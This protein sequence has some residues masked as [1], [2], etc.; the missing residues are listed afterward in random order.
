MEKKLKAIGYVRVST[1][2]QAASGLSIEA[3]EAKIRQYCQLNDL[4]LVRIYC[5]AG[6]SGKSLNRPMV[7]EALRALHTKEAQT[8]VVLKL[9]RLS[10][11]TRDILDLADLCQKEE[12][13]LASLSEKLDT[14]SASGRLVLSVLA[15]MVQFEREQGVERTRL[16]LQAKRSRGELVGEVPVGFRLADDK[17]TLLP[18]EREQAA[19]TKIKV[20]RERK[21]LSFGAI[22]T[23]LNA[24]G[25]RAKQGG[26]WHRR[27][28]QRAYERSLS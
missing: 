20:L 16:A 12:W 23:V 17:K 4:E 5:D 21:N 7:Q 27:V 3:Q 6:V 18:D 24:V 22:A 14:C 26:N 15:S 1:E 11:S 28:V 2:E 10:R 9:D 25:I 19:I 13:C 8:L